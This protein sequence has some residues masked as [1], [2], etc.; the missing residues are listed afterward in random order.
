LLREGTAGPS[1]AGFLTAPVLGRSS[2]IK[3]G[4][5]PKCCLCCLAR[6][7]GPLAPDAVAPNKPYSRSHCRG[8]RTHRRRACHRRDKRKCRGCRRMGLCD[9]VATNEPI[10]GRFRRCGTNPRGGRTEGNVLGWRNRKREEPSPTL[11]RSYGR[12]DRTHRLDGV[13]PR[14]MMPPDRLS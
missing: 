8:E 1:A 9:A 3:C 7:A 12:G 14:K 5:K 4:T 6:R 10:S 13:P 11:P 2:V